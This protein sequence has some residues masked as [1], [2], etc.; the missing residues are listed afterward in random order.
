M[1][2]SPVKVRVCVC[3]CVCVCVWLPEAQAP[4]PFLSCGRSIPG[5]GLRAPAP[6]RPPPPCPQSAQQEGERV[7]RSEFPFLFLFWHHLEVAHVPLLPFHQLEL[8]LSA[9]PKLQAGQGDVVLT[10]TCIQPK[11]RGLAPWGEGSRNLGR[12]RADWPDMPPPALSPPPSGF[13]LCG[14]L[15]VL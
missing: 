10:R 12:Q 2:L 4:R 5:C 1:F 13:R 14:L 7:K 8:D 11:F 9:T 3:V 6:R 15:A